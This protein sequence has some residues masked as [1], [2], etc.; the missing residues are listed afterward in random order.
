M[1]RTNA[2]MPGVWAGAPEM[3]A[4]AAAAVVVPVAAA[5]DVAAVA[6]VAVATAVADVDAV[7]AACVGNEVWLEEGPTVW[8]KVLN[9]LAN[10]SVDAVGS[11]DSKVGLVGPVVVGKEPVGRV[12]TRSGLILVGSMTTAVCAVTLIRQPHWHFRRRSYAIEN[13]ETGA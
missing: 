10:G 4:G 11:G 5:V 9:I 3:A 13:R 7:A 2:E 12:P 1:A 8:L 6:V